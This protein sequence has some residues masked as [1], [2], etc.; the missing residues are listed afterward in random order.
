MPQAA[1]CTLLP[2][3][4]SP[5]M[6]RDALRRWPAGQPLAALC[7]MPRT[8]S[9]PR[10]AGW[11][12]LAS[13]EPPVLIAATDPDP[14][15]RLASAIQSTRQ[16]GRVQ[17]HPVPF[18]GGWMVALGYEL[19]RFIEPT[20][21]GT[22][23]RVDADWPWSI[24]LWRVPGALAYEHGAERWWSVG[25]VEAALLDRL[26]MPSGDANAETYVLAEPM[27]AR[28]RAEYLAAVARGVEYIHAGDC[29]Q[30]NLS[31]RIRAG[32]RGS[33]R[34]LFG[35]M[36]EA[37]SPWYGAY[38]EVPTASG[39]H[40]AMSVSPELFLDYR[41]ATRSVTT[42]P[43]KGTRA[44]RTDPSELRS[45]IKD[46]AELAMI[47]DLMRNDLGRVCEI[48]SVRVDEEQAIERHGYPGSLGYPNTGVHHG[49]ATIRG[50]LR[51]DRSAADLLRA[52]F[53]GGSITGA[54]KVRAM[55]IIEELEP[56][57]R[58]LYTGA[59][60]YLSDCGNISLNIA[61]RT[62][63]VRAGQLTFGAGAGIV[64]DS[65]PE[66]EWQETLDKAGFLSSV[67]T[68]H[69]PTSV[70]TTRCVSAQEQ[71]A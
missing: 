7:S 48:G 5:P 14:L 52:T 46:R 26:R 55:Q 53:P 69:A 58:G 19:G 16:P 12:F 4:T 17:E 22:A 65:I 51:P 13:P 10:W 50:T 27:P 1:R 45:S 36:L 49:V 15:G 56:K 38:L 40:A 35:A 8:G 42:R 18:V 32:F 6:P 63:V 44:G 64:A 41:A 28:L 23:E 11:S 43:I 34:A 21:A 37:A 30:V 2:T 67:A 66:Q 31:H 29:F 68:T 20:A 71:S 39:L 24:V 61:I 47:I 54:P 62:A 59:I 33:P 25:D 70:H 60:G 57:P 3:L 9:D